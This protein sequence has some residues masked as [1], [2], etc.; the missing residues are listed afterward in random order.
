MIPALFAMLSLANEGVGNQH[1]ALSKGQDGNNGIQGRK[2]A[3]KR[4]RLSY[5][6]L[7]EL[8][9]DVCYQQNVYAGWGRG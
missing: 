2:E 1:S 4:G 8:G 5:D 3:K 9:F 6:C 7:V